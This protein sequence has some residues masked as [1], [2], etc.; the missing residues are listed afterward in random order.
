MIFGAY[1]PKKIRNSNNNMIMIMS[2]RSNL[3][4]TKNYPEN[5]NNFLTMC[6][7][8]IWRPRHKANFRFV[9]KRSND[10]G[11]AVQAFNASIS[12]WATASSSCLHRLDTLMA[13]R[14]SGSFWCLLYLTVL[15]ICLYLLVIFVHLTS[16]TWPTTYFLFVIGVT[17]WPIYT[18]NPRFSFISV[19]VS[20]VYSLFFSLLS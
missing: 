3:T 17:L 14:I 19:F 1:T 13:V 7:T 11:S 2:S 18:V 8:S 16:S 20:F 9:S 12:L 10:R 15:S 6:H 5:G 4:I